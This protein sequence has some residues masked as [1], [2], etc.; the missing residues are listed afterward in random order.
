MGLPTTDILITLD[1][2][3]FFPILNPFFDLVTYYEKLQYYFDLIFPLEI[4]GFGL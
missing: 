3:P 2:Q 4:L 1:S